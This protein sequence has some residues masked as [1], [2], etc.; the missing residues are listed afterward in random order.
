MLKYLIIC[1]HPDDETLGLGGTIK[2]LNKKKA[3]ISCLVFTEGESAR[4]KS[5]RRIKDRENQSK[6]ASKILGIN[7]I[8]FLRYKDQQLDMVP[9]VELAQKIELKI[10]KLKPK[11]VFTHFWGDVNQDHRKLFEATL[12]AC[13]P[14]PSSSVKELICYETPSSTEWGIESFNPNYFVDIDKELEIKIKAFK[15]YKNEIAT[16]PH[17]RS[18]KSITNR[19][20][21]WG[22]KVGIKN[23][24]AFIKVRELI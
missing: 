18:I 5:L 19:A 24:E 11:V 12:I 23:A 15:Q 6:K 2:I 8:Q 21:Y 14:T 7:Q 1:A 3:D 4:E 13:R 16:F 9:V 17:P 20:A 10:K 22:S